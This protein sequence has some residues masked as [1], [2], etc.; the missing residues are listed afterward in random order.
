MSPPDEF[1]FKEM[2]TWGP[3]KISS[4]WLCVWCESKEIGRGTGA[5][6]PST[7][8][9]ESSADFLPTM[10]S[11]YTKQYRIL[12]NINYGVNLQKCVERAPL[13]DQANGALC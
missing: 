1:S 2:M 3:F 6:I 4:G 8:G 10:G 13:D 11:Y 7:N 12:S 9:G 5:K